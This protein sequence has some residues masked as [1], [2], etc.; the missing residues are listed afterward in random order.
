MNYADSPLAELGLSVSTHAKQRFYDRFRRDATR[1][2][3]I[4]IGIN[5]LVRRGV[6][7]RAEMRMSG[8]FVYLTSGH[9]GFVLAEGR[10]GI[11]VVTC[12]H[13]SQWDSKCAS[14]LKLNPGDNPKKLKKRIKNLRRN[15]IKKLITHLKGA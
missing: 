15:S 8:F 5:E 14:M 7:Y 1:L 11:I 2:V 12:V 10:N 4:E 3:S 9:V 6:I 13:P